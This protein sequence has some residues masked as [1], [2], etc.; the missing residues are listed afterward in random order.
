MNNI[1]QKLYDE[2]DQYEKF[3]QYITKAD[4]A[5]IA[6]RIV[7]E[8]AEKSFEYGWERSNNDITGV[9]E[10]F[11]ED[12]LGEQRGFAEFTISILTFKGVCG[13]ITGPTINDLPMKVGF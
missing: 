11:K 10:E 8:V 5:R 6:A 3:S 1:E 13:S 9:F 7:L 2:F 4:A 12:L